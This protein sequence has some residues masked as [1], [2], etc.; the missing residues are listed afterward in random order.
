MA[1]RPAPAVRNPLLALRR[2]VEAPELEAEPDAAEGLEPVAL[3]VGSSA[4]AVAERTP[5]RA[6]ADHHHVELHHRSEEVGLQAR[7]GPL[8][9]RPP[10]KRPRSRGRRERT[11]PIPDRPVRALIT[12]TPVPAPAVDA[13]DGRPGPDPV[14]APD[15][16]DAGPGDADRFPGS[17][18][19]GTGEAAGSQSA[20]A[21]AGDPL[22]P[23]AGTAGAAG[24]VDARA[25]S[26]VGV[27]G[28]SPLHAAAG[29]WSTW[30]D[31][32]PSTPTLLRLGGPSAA[33]GATG[34]A[35]GRSA[36]V[37]KGVPAVSARG[38]GVADAPTVPTRPPPRRDPT[39]APLTARAAPPAPAPER[40]RI[41][42]LPATAARRPAPD[43]ILGPATQPL[44]FPP[45]ALLPSIAEP[46][47]PTE[48]TGRR[49]MTV[50]QAAITMVVALSLWALVDAP[51]LLH[52]AQTAP[53]GA[54]RDAALAL[55]R[56][57]D[58]VSAALGLDRVTH[59]VDDLLGRHP[60]APPAVIPL[61]PRASGRRSGPLAGRAGTVTG[62][63]GAPGAPSAAATPAHLPPLRVGTAADPLRVLVVGD[64]LGL[65]FG[66]SVQNKLDAGGIIHTQVDGRVATGLTRPDSFDWS[67]ELQSD[68]TQFRPELVIAMFG[69]ND[70]QDAIVG[71]R[72]IPFLSQAWGE[73]YGSRVA[74][75]ADAVHASGAHLL[76]AGLPVMRSAVKTQRLQIVMAVTRAVLAGRDSTMFV[77]ETATLA[78]GAGHYAYAL[79]DAAGQLVVV[80]EPDGVHFS[81]AGADWLADRAITTMVSGWHLLLRP[82]A[83]S[84]GQ[85]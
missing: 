38:A 24:G 50:V 40:A 5:P 61:T 70:D 55:L 82:L 68:L 72:F 46:A 77:D 57:L 74:S 65:D 4:L 25:G 13:G 80:R 2:V 20:D 16:P 8:E 48:R 10:A 26:P 19:P 75:F 22:A 51:A 34:T 41:H 54:R 66:D 79:T 21:E 6:H 85:A 42:A 56:P 45:S 29:P 83:R 64:S 76:W 73:I 14:G 84:A 71:G 3:S 31:A 23:D 52:G 27:G 58:R 1:W 37:I 39:P 30:P 81:P 35:T 47:T 9:D 33:S 32:P 15:S 7:P 69:G 18:D 12:S 28:T 67:A 63:P 36:T 60:A 49:P 62:A 53:R 17:R 11:Q 43:L 78:D 44:E 59:V